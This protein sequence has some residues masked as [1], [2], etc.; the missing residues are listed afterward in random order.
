[1]LTAM[2]PVFGI[3]LTTVPPFMQ[4]VLVTAEQSFER[5]KYALKKMVRMVVCVYFSHAIGDLRAS[6][7]VRCYAL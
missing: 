5:Y 6:L 7:L 2:L 4:V 1:M 3:A